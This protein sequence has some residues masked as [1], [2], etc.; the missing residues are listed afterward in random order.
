MIHW[1]RVSKKEQKIITQIVNRLID[2]G[3]RDGQPIDR[4]SAEMDITAAHMV[5]PLW[6]DDLLASDEFNFRHDVYGIMNHIDRRTGKMLDH[7][8]PRFTRST[9]RTIKL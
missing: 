6:L 4:Q 8:T 7:F 5:S 3:Y 9:G 1:N 2:Y